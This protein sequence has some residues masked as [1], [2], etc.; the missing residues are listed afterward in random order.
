MG[1]LGLARSRLE[2]VTKQGARS[3]A[4]YTHSVKMAG[5]AEARVVS[6]EELCKT[7]FLRMVDIQYQR[8]P[9]K[10]VQHWQSCERTT[11]DQSIGIDGMRG[12]PPLYDALLQQ[13]MFLLYA[14]AC[15]Q[16]S[17]KKLRLVG[18][19]NKSGMLCPRQCSQ[20]QASA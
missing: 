3:V 13:H 19:S 12:T 5:M 4:A 6:K 15:H 14:M 11:T 1:M 7:K 2:L 17:S 16:A 10:P 9:D 20:T 18:P 8:A